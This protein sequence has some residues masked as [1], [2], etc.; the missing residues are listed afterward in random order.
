[1]DFGSLGHKL[2]LGRGAEIEVVEAEDWRTKD[3]K[4]ARDDIRA[5]GR[6]P[7]LRKDFDRGDAV[8]QSFFR[9]LERFDLRAVWDAGQ[10]EVIALWDEGGGVQCRCLLDRLAIDEEKKRAVILDPKFSDALN[11]QSIGRHLFNQ[12]YHVQEQWYTRGVE[13]C[14]PEL[15]GRVDFIF[16][17][18]ETEPPYQMVPVTLNGE[19]KMLGISKAMR[20]VDAWKA[21][22]KAGRWPGYTEQVVRAEPPT[23][24]LNAEMGS[25]AI[26]PI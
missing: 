25:N 1:M 15:G 2:V 12:N 26:K 14:R 21:C 23:W 24:A 8:A 16:L 18:M 19:F 20:A 4:A 9:E 5:A 11:P 13:F 10:S 17:F 7:A 6:I 22:L 3:A